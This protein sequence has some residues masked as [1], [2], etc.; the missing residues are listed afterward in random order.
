MR[1]KQANSGTF[2]RGLIQVMFDRVHQ[3]LTK[4][5]AMI[6]GVNGNILYV[7]E[8]GTITDH[9]GQISL[10]RFKSIMEEDAP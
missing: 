1:R 4:F 9:T 6:G 8:Q 7:K 5:Q 3:V 10:C 2:F